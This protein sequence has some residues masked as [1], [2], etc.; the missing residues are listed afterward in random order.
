M[1]ALED[2]TEEKPS[3]YPVTI[4][5]DRYRGVYSG[6]KWIALAGDDHGDLDWFPVLRTAMDDWGPHGGN[7]A[8]KDFWSE[9]HANISVG[10][11]PDEAYANLLKKIGAKTCPK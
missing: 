11:T 10:D 7:I 3:P 5:Q 4:I 9:E 1:P 8:A 2:E 6:G